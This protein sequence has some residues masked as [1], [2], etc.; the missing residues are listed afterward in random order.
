MAASSDDVGTVI[1]QLL[2]NETAVF[3]DVTELLLKFGSNPEYLVLNKDVPLDNLQRLHSELETSRNKKLGKDTAISQMPTS[4]SVV[5]PTASSSVAGAT[6]MT[7]SSQNFQ[8]TEPEFF[9]KLR[10]NFDHVLIYEDRSLQEKARSLIPL[11]ELSKIAGEKFKN[12]QES[13]KDIPGEKALDMRDCLLIEMINWFKTSFFSW[14]NSPKCDRCGGETKH[15]GMATPSADD[16]KWGASRV[17]EYECNNCHQ[18]VQFPRYNHPGKLLETRTGRCGEWANCF[19]LCCRAI[20]FEARYVMDWTDHVWTEVFSNS[21]QRWLHCDTCENGC[22]KPLLYEVGWG[23]KL[24]YIIAFSKDER[25]EGQPADRKR[26]LEL[27]S[28]AEVVE[29]LKPKEVKEEEMGGRTSGSLAWRLSRGETTR[30]QKQHEP[31]IFKLTPAEIKNKNLRVTYCCS[32]DKYLR[33]S[34]NNSEQSGWNS[35]VF[36][37]ANIARKEEHDWKMVYL[38]RTPDCNNARISWKFDF[39]CSSL[40]VDKITILTRSKTYENGV[41]SWKLL[42]S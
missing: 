36:E 17:E 40:V 1:G 31:F 27:R 28:V 7:T 33:I 16:L 32:T 22:D 13:M 5:A 4:P 10:N 3:L 41:V 8:V 29:F 26:I 25:Q 2:E 30:S 15:T 14:M 34:D 24:S 20:G 18:F 23:K 35:Q 42:Q 38:A 12:L 39:S 6:G 37:Y 11:S 9:Q 19:T 21:Q